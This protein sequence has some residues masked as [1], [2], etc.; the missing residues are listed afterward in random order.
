MDSSKRA[1]IGFIAAILAVGLVRFALTV[2]G[3]PNTL[4]KYASMSV[5]ILM[6][7]LYFGVVA[8]SWKEQ[9]VLSYLLI[10]PYMAVELAGIGYTWATGKATIFH[11]PEYSFGLEIAPHFWGHLV[12][13]LTWEPLAVFVTMVVVG[14][15]SKLFRR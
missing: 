5:V 11:A 7:A 15:A 6:G 1:C 10:L 13:G 2:S 4:T 9:L 8:H 3:V 12:G 14:A